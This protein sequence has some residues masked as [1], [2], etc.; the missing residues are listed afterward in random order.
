M[1]D[2][3]ARQGILK[4]VRLVIVD[5]QPIVLQGLKS[6]LGAQQDFDVV[7]SSSDGTSCLEAI[8]N[9]TPDVALI[10]DALPDLRAS[11]ILAIAKA[12]KLSTRLVFFTD[13]DIDHGLTAAIAAGA[14]SVISKYAA[15]AIMLQ[16][17]RLMTTSGVSL[18][19]RDSI[20][21][22]ANGGQ[23]EK[24]LE[25]LTDRERQIARLVSEG[26]S[27]KEI[28][29]HLDVSQGTVK[30]HLYNI[31]QKLE[32]TNRTVLA[33]IALLQRT[34]GFGALAL[35]FLAFA[36]ADEL[37]ASE[38][39]D[40]WPD[41]NSIGLAGEHAVYEVFKKAILQRL[42]VSE[43][44]ETP[45]FTERDFVAKTIQVTNPAA[46]MEALRA[47]EQFIGSKPWADYGPA[48]S[49]ASNFPA[50]FLQETSNTQIGRELFPQHQLPRLASDPMIHGGYGTFAALAGA[51]IYALS[52]SEAAAQSHDPGQ[53]S[54]DS[55][56][57][58]LGGNASTK[59]A[60]TTH[61]PANHADNSAPDFPSH[62]SG[63]PSTFVKTAIDIAKEGVGSQAAPDVAG[64]N[65]QKA[66]GLDLDFG[67][68]GHSRDQLMGGNFENV[69]HR[70][71]IDSKSRSSDSAS[72]D[73]ASSDSV[74]SDS[75]LDFAS[76][77]G[78]LNL[79][80]FGGL[81]WLHLTAAAKS[82]PPHTLAW[83]Y[84]PAS[85]QTIVYVNSTDRSLDIGDRGLL[86][87]H[88][89]G[90]V[91]VAES[92]FVHQAEGTVVA[93]TLEQLEQALPSGTAADDTVLSTPGTHS[94]EGALGESGVWSAF[95][96]EGFS[97]Q[98][99]QARSG[100]GTSTKFKTF[101]RDS[102]DRADESGDVS[103][104]SAH[105]SS[106]GAGQ[107]AAAPAGEKLTSNSEAMKADTDAL[108]T[109][110]N[111]MIPP[112]LAT[113]DNTSHRNS[114][115]ASETGVGKADHGSDET[116]GN[117]IGKDAEHH[118]P[119]S[120][121]ANG[122]AAEKMPEPAAV[123][124]GNAG[125]D[126]HP[127]SANAPEA[128]ANADSADGGHSHHGSEPGSAKVASKETA[129][130]KST[131]DKG[132]GNDNGHHS[133]AS[134]DSRASAKAAEK[135][136]VEHSNPGHSTSA[137]APEAEP[138]DATAHGVGRD[139]SQHASH[140]DSAKAAG[141]K[142]EAKSMPDNGVG[143]GTEGNHNEHHSS[144]SN[145]SRGEVKTTDPIGVEH[146]NPGQ[147]GGGNAQQ[148]AHAHAPASELVQPAKAASQSG[149]VDHEPAFRFDGG[150]GPSTPAA[151]IEPKKLD[152]P[153]VPQAQKNDVQLI[154][155]MVPGTLDEHAAHQDGHAPHHG[156]GPAAHD[157]LI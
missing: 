93:S 82:I 46:A 75:V 106:N 41:D 134:D 74:S 123:E 9:L 45:R 1:L 55:F 139:S 109:Q 60:A 136:G 83:V 39:N 119:A 94:A 47:A 26:M 92:D 67:P 4:P 76:G 16:S 132:P 98:F 121:A 120:E 6:V 151:V 78:R 86:E 107:G 148:A 35:A 33:T 140:P 65:L 126:K 43:S 18:Q 57:A 89:Q 10:A 22:E 63:R 112:G 21:K 108:S 48:G 50:L 12:E 90:I 72:S 51:L 87:I 103:G 96:D 97:F 115:H 20:D 70:A 156:L 52:E 147:A 118:A 154:V 30:V 73:S 157:W 24:K 64:D 129:E 2:A 53:A 49:S 40:N 150:A 84:D 81:A 131:P 42:V 144:A 137:N 61:V 110:Q 14:C 8:R 125:H 100:F 122:S 7:A 114:D 88:L 3:S 32:I 38:V 145:N 101:T 113:A 95:A 59:L 155:D 25:L 141:E 19:Q 58:T 85:N 133:S 102:S 54:I 146:G 105:G 143:N 28:A 36:I 117:G 138:S 44:G 91:S 11:E 99:A 37:K 124:H 111:E 71:P 79:A 23:I 104:V 149:G 56:L 127:S 27:N 69:V 34:S 15:P 66:V 128:A 116:R 31:F 13:C 68:G 80:A 152:D 17:L 135:G 5:R 62:E 130:A 77:P 29:R 153:Y 142:A